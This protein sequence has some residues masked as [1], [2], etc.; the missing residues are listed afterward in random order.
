MTEAGDWFARAD[1]TLARVGQQVAAAQERAATASR[2]RAELDRVRGQARSPRGEV[3]VSADA[4]GRVVDLRFAEDA[5]ELSARDLSRLTL[6]TIAAA[7]AASG[8]AA[9]EVARA[10]WGEDSP[11]V[12][13]LA[14]E[15]SG[16]SG[17][18]QER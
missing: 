2:V 1:E 7:R 13:A 18:D 10:A 15:L 3:T 6:E 14:A 16:A 8:A 9:L 5:V 17:P 11:T 4:T 12:A